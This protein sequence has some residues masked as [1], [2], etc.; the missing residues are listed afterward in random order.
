[1]M[2]QNQILLLDY[3]VISKNVC[4]PLSTRYISPDVLVVPVYLWRIFPSICKAAQ[5]STHRILEL[6]IIISGWNRKFC[7]SNDSGD[8]HDDKCFFMMLKGRDF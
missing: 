7:I 1:M 8:S 2:S 3:S 6:R 4:S 5:P